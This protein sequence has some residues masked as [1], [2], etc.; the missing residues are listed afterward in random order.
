M[1]SSRALRWTAYVAAALV[2]WFAL[3]AIRLI[4]P[5]VAEFWFVIILA[6]GTLMWMD[7]GTPLLVTFSWTIPQAVLF[8]LAEFWLPYPLSLAVLLVAGAWFLGMGFVQP[9]YSWWMRSILRI[10]AKR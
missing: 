5:P 3:D 7:A 10:D 2:G 9:F 6:G 4:S 1:D 8:A